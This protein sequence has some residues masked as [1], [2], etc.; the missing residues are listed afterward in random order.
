MRNVPIFE[1]FILVL[2][3]LEAVTLVSFD[4]FTPRS[5][6]YQLMAGIMP[7]GAWGLMCFLAVFCQSIGLLLNIR[8]FRYIGLGI[9]GTFFVCLF[10]I[11]TFEFPNLMTGISAALA[12]FCFVSWSFVRNTDTVQSSTDDIMKEEH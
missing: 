9:S 2:M 1:T 3:G 10:V 6:F 7:Q 12:V 11:N 8:I 5:E 4:V